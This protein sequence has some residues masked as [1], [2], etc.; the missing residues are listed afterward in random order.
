M[1]SVPGSAFE[2]RL[3]VVED[4]PLM[5][6]LLRD[7]LVQ[8]GFGTQLVISA[9]EAKRAIESFDPD[10]VL[11]DVNLG[12]GPNGIQLVHMLLHSRPDIV[13]ILLSKFAD[14]ASAGIVDELPAGVTFLRKG[15]MHDTRA[16]TDAINA[17]LTDASARVR[18]DELSKGTL[19]ALTKPQREILHLMARGLSNKEIARQRAVSVSNIEHR[20]TAIYKALQIPTSDDVMPR[21]AAIRLYIASAGMPE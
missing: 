8:H 4:D 12:S 15:L 7:A 1:S 20:A 3:L 18:Q 11:I 21:V 16:L 10:A 19:D 17:A 6:S 14:L 5:G 13:P 9:V 2:R